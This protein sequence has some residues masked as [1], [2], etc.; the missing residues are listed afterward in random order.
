MLLEA[1]KDGEQLFRRHTLGFV[2]LVVKIVTKAHL[3]SETVS[4][5]NQLRQAVMQ[6]PLLQ[7]TQRVLRAAT[8]LFIF[9][10]RLIG[11]Q[12]AERGVHPLPGGI[13]M[14][15]RVG[16][17]P[18]IQVRLGTD[19]LIQQRLSLGIFNGV[20]VKETQPA[21]QPMLQ[22]IA[23]CVLRQNFQPSQQLTNFRQSTRF[24]DKAFISAFRRRKTC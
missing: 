18:G 7:F 24:G 12:L 21:I 19:D 5:A 6:Q 15:D 2:H 1:I 16:L 17:A 22:R 9:I 8:I 14:A 10:G 13:Q 23:L 20:T 3:A 4:Q 11:Q